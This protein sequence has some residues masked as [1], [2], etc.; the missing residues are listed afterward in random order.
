MIGPLPTTTWM[1]EEAPLM[2][3][4][5]ALDVPRSQESL[6]RWQMLTGQWR[7]VL[8]E[9]IDA[10][11]GTERA[12]AWRVIDMSSNQFRAACMALSTLYVDP[13]TVTGGSPDV[14]EALE[15]AGTWELLLTGQRDCLGLREWALRVDPTPDGGIVVRPALPHRLSAEATA[16]APDVPIRVRE[17]VRVARERTQWAVEE[18]DAS[19]PTNPGRRLLDVASGEQL[20]ELPWLWWAEDGRAILPYSLYHAERTGCLWSPTEWQELVE[21]TVMCALHW[22]YFAHVVRTCY[23]QRYAIGLEVAGDA[24]DHG[25]PG[26]RRSVTSDPAKIWMPQVTE[27]TTSYTV[28]AYPIPVS[29]RD[30]EEALSSY[31]RRVAAAA[32]LSPTDVA[33]VQ[34]DPRS[35]YALALSSEGQQRAARRY[36]RQFRRGDLQT[37]R[38]AAAALGWAHGRVYPTTGYEIAYASDPASAEESPFASVGLPAL[39]QSGIVS[40]PEARTML[41]VTGPAPPDTTPTETPDG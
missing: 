14:A 2:R 27:G 4:Y 29:P 32:G 37:I 18:C 41:G 31:E 21:G 12:E 7:H 11:V 39:V 5:S 28:G 34:G 40:R 26:A 36:R 15:E 33:R 17:L 25:T 38:I 16:S 8:E 6:R 23:A 9:S 3:G 13:P 1:V 20:E 30:L 10:I 22:T 19:D 24:P 35:G